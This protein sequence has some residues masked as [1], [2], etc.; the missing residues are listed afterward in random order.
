MAFFGVICVEVV[1]FELLNNE[2]MNLL[3]IIAFSLISISQAV[4]V[5]WFNWLFQMNDNL[6]LLGSFLVYLLFGLIFL[7]ILQLRN[8]TFLIVAL[9]PILVFSFLVYE[10]N[11]TLVLLRIVHVI[12]ALFW[13][14]MLLKSPWHKKSFKIGVPLGLAAN[15]GVFAIFYLFVFPQ[16]DV[17]A[18]NQSLYINQQYLLDNTIVTDKKG[19]KLEFEK[20]EISVLNFTFIN[21]RPCRAKSASYDQLKNHFRK[22]K[23][24]KFYTI[25][26]VEG[27]ESFKEYYAKVSNAY[28]DQDGLLAD[29]LNCNDG[30]PTELVIDKKGII[31]NQFDGFNDRMAND[32]LK[33]RISL[34][35][36]LKNEK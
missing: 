13:C 20:G 28:H 24:V 6:N 35:N 25:H 3:K 22:D 23:S 29:K 9:A 2:K 12:L 33:N 19:K 1:V 36:K 15:L 14:L 10:G 31:R 34:I 26:E 8:I 16:M 7:P 18:A 4:L 32:Y 21:C 17:V 11:P 30:F 5:F 27:Y